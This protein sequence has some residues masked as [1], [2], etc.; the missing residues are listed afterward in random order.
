[1]A[2]RRISKPKITKP[3]GRPTVA[4]KIVEA[5]LL[6]SVADFQQWQ[7]INDKIATGKSINGWKII[8]KETRGKLAYKGVIKGVPYIN[9]VLFGR[10][11][12]KAPPINDLM[13]WVRVK[14]IR[15]RGK[16]IRQIAYL[17]G[18]KIAKEGTNPPFL[19]QRIKTTMIQFNTRQALKAGTPIF[20]AI[21]ASDFMK[22]IDTT[23]TKLNKGT[24]AV[25]VKTSYNQNEG[26]VTDYN[27]SLGS[28]LI[29]KRYKL[30]DF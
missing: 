28:S 24:K 22:D 16:T 13:K 27:L 4:L 3:S 23:L 29:N 19:T 25:N 11:P 7:S 14:G 8:I 10:G 21:G 9:D 2:V 5:A 12:G 30:E 20:A 18:K 26:K 6:M 17:V 15:D 1:M